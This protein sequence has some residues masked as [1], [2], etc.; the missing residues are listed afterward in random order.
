MTT[1]LSRSSKLAP[2]LGAGDE[3]AHVEREDPLRL[4]PL[5]HVALDDPDRQPLG[6][7][8]LAHAGLADQDRVVLRPAR[9]DLEHAA[10]LVVAPDD[11]VDPPLPRGLVE[12][13]G[14]AVQGVVLALG[15]GVL[16]ALPAADVAEDGAE[17]VLGHALALERIRDRAGALGERHQEVLAR[18]VLV[19]QRLG[20]FEGEVERAVQVLPDVLAGHA[21]AGHGREFFDGPVREGRERVGVGAEAREEGV[22][23]AALVL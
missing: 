17:R 14:V 2:V 8:R 12:V 16:H 1:A 20:L 19:A 13:A 23:E 6:D 3:R 5:G 11:R 18:D 9:E 15:V 4:E 21:G 7:G 22:D 10:D